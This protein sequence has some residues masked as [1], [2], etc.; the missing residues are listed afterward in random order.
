MTPSSAACSEL[1]DRVLGEHLAVTRAG[2]AAGRRVAHDLATDAVDD[3][4]RVGRLVERGQQPVLHRF[5]LRDAIVGLA[6][7]LGD[8][9]DQR[10][11]I[12]TSTAR[13]TRSSSRRGE[14]LADDV[15]DDDPPDQSDDDEQ[16]RHHRGQA[17]R[18]IRTD[19]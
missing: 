15:R 16:T 12:G 10:E 2:E 19:R 14:Q 9:I 11:I 1:V 4:D 17:R 18:L 3:D 13:R 5:R 6:L 8:G 7:L